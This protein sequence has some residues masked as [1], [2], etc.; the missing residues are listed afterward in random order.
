MKYALAALIFLMIAMLWHATSEAVT[1]YG[2]Y[3]QWCSAYG[4]CKDD[5]GPQEAVTIIEK[6]FANK[7]LTAVIIRHKGRF[8]EVDI[9][10]RNMP[11][12]RILFDRKTGRFRS[13]Y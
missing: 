10:N 1:P 7:G 3:C 6:Y 8:I 12:D 13:T 5:L 11:F 9:Y 2:D 4:I